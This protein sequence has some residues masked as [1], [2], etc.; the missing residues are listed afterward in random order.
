[1]ESEREQIIWRLQRLLGDQCDQGRVMEG[2]VQPSESICTEDFV[3]CFREEM[4]DL[5]PLDHDA[6]QCHHASGTSNGAHLQS[7]EPNEVQKP[8]EPKEHL[9][10]YRARTSEEAENGGRLEVNKLERSKFCFSHIQR[11]FVFHKYC[12]LE[13]V[14]VVFK[15]NTTQLALWAF[16]NDLARYKLNLIECLK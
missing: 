5:H 11:F 1:M 15:Y 4:V 10:N 6:K 3:Q 7:E 12:F 14:C 13:E 2:A 16:L 8:K 9:S